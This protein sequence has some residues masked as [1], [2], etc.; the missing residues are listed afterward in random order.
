MW[1]LVVIIF[2]ICIILPQALLE[3]KEQLGPNATMP[4]FLE[5]LKCFRNDIYHEIFKLCGVKLK[6]K[7]SCNSVHYVWGHIS[8]CSCKVC[9]RPTAV[10]SIDSHVNMAL[11]NDVYLPSLEIP[12][13]WP[14]KKLLMLRTKSLSFC[15]WVHDSFYSTKCSEKFGQVR[16]DVQVCPGMFFKQGHT[17]V[18]VPKFLLKIY[19]ANV[20]PMWPLLPSWQHFFGKSMKRGLQF[21]RLELSKLLFSW[22]IPPFMAPADFSWRPYIP[23]KASL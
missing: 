5:E 7:L 21:H 11:K 1:N 23:N 18:C 4:A 10:E 19:D 14:W 17:Q 20:V 13:K 2:S 8:C 9:R 12:A 22:R 6:Q 3:W 15:C 16:Q